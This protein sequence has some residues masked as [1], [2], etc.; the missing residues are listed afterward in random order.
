MEWHDLKWYEKILTVIVGLIV[1]FYILI[2]P[3]IPQLVYPQ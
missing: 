3:M 1:L 2:V